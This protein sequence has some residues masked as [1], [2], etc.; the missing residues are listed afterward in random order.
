MMKRRNNREVQLRKPEG[1][2]KEE[3]LL[4]EDDLA[5]EQEG[6]GVK[7]D[8]G[9]ENEERAV[10]HVLIYGEDLLVGIPANRKITISL[11][12]TLTA[13]LNKWNQMISFSGL[14]RKQGV[15]LEKSEELIG[16][17]LTETVLCESLKH[18]LDVGLQEIHSNVA[19]KGIW[20]EEVNQKRRR[21]ESLAHQSK[22]KCEG[23]FKWNSE[24]ALMLNSRLERVSILRRKE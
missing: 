24:D 14:T 2:S 8:R 19:R 21:S 3:D 11:T 13:R 6:M 4:L 18:L 17:D 9:R 16:G 12:L 22:Q 1:V 7:V 5:F 20:V 10:A 23:K 15:L